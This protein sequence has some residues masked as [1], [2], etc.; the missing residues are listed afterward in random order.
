MNTYYVT[1]DQVT[2]IVSAEWYSLADGVKFNY[3]SPVL[4]FYTGKTPNQKLVAMFNKWDF[5]TVDNE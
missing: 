2:K 1:S 3:K 5:V 4:R